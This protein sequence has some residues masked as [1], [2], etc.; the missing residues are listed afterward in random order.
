MPAQIRTGSETISLHFSLPRQELHRVL[1]AMNELLKVAVALI[2]AVLLMC[3]LENLLREALCLTEM[4]ESPRMGSTCISRVSLKI[5]KD[6][7][8]SEGLFPAILSLYVFPLAWL[9]AFHFPLPPA[10][11]PALIHLFLCSSDS[12][13]HSQL[14]LGSLPQ[15][16]C[17]LTVHLT[18][19]TS[20]HS[21]LLY[22]LL[23]V[24]FFPFCLSALY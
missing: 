10:W 24:F 19:H 7:D 16:T 20:R 15:L 23:P 9:S 18:L 5:C 11:L 17:I 12:L 14:H 6:K 4:A 13:I 21:S 8:S 3:H 2:L 1:F 22:C